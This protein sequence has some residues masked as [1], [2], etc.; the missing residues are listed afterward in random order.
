[1][2][3]HWLNYKASVLSHRLNFEKQIK[4]GNCATNVNSSKALYRG[5]S[6][7]KWHHESVQE[8]HLRDEAESTDET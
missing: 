3:S 6:I 1:V 7:A 4:W 5:V 8:S 2:L